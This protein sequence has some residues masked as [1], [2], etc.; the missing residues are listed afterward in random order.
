E[1]LAEARSSVAFNLAQVGLLSKAQSY[2][3]ENKIDV[4]LL[5]LSLPDS[6]GVN[7]FKQI[8]SM[9]Q[10]IPI[11]LLSGLTDE[12]L[13][14]QLVHQ[15]AQ[16]Y[17]IK[18]Q[19]NGDLLIR[20]IRYAIER[21]SA[22][23]ALKENEDRYRKLYESAPVG[24]QS[25]D[26]DGR[27]IVVNQTWLDILGYTLEEVL[28]KWFGDFLAPGG[29]ELFRQRFPLFKAAGEVHNE[30]KMARKDGT[31]I[32]VAFDG[33]IGY[34]INGD[35][36][37]TH[38]VLNDITQKKISEKAVLE[39]A[40]QWKSTFDSVPDGICLLDNER[41]ILRANQAMAD[42]FLMQTHEMIGKHCW[43]VVHLANDPFCNCPFPCVESSLSH[44]SMEISRG[45]QWL[46][47]TIDPIV[48]GDRKMTGAVHIVRDITERK[49]SEIARK[50]SEERYR[51]LFENSPISLWEE[52]FSLVKHRLDTLREHGVQDLRS[53]LNEH[54]DVVQEFIRM[55][56]VLDVN[57]ATL[58]MFGAK[59]KEE[60]LSNLGLV[61]G[62]ESVN[63]FQNE[64][65]CIWD[66][67]NEFS[68]EGNNRTLTGDRI[69]VSLGWSVTPGN[70][71]TL[72]KVIVSLIDITESKR[73]REK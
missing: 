66:G 52:D 41:R 12:D 28:G 58:R 45:N 67:I 53:Y 40:A 56:K 32:D 50:E 61:F 16:D 5:D 71:A 22:E 46:E 33:K 19:T 44:Q 24:Y 21:T 10:W 17:L 47:I 34:D 36:L 26:A 70:E 38:C 62:P 6:S 15:G 73:S 7:T 65:L 13:A 55:V 49:I 30:F 14:D 68:W 48:A 72:S 60:L 59:K 29:A 69:N 11:I 42:M 31:L 25:L 54:P 23:K 1:A 20:S 9:V 4:I 27:F 37:Q 57:N 39:A 35:F 63:Q 18:G 3:N 8:Q 2:L 43:E 64:L 51:G